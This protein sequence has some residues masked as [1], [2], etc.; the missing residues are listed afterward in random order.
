MCTHSAWNIS[1]TFAKTEQWETQHHLLVSATLAYSV[2]CTDV[3]ITWKQ[4]VFGLHCKVLA[5]GAKNFWQLPEIFPMSDEASASR[6]QDRLAT[7]QGQANRG[8]GSNSG[9]TYLRRRKNLQNSNQKT[10]V[11]TWEK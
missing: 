7:E 1:S 8:S 4:T 6:L 3:G 5:T 10:E 11:V 2:F 9:A